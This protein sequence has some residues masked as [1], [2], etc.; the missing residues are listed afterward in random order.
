MTAQLY[1]EAIQILELL[2]QGKNPVTKQPV[3]STHFLHDT[4]IIRPLS[5]L[6]GTIQQVKTSKTAKEFVIPQ[7]VLEG[8]P[9][10]KG[11]QIGVNEFCRHVNYLIVPYGSKQVTS[12]HLFDRLK[13]LGMLSEETTSEGGKRTVLNESS[14]GYGISTTERN[15]KGRPYTQIVF[16]EQGVQLLTKLV[17]ELAFPRVMTPR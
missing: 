17:E 6:L 10:W 13:Q 4:D 12:K 15:F 8:L 7:G 11:T 5:F 1:R 14:E 2:T 9:D 16:D 3:E